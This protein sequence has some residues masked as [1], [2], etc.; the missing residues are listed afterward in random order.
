MESHHQPENSN[1]FLESARREAVKTI[2]SH[3]KGQR[4]DISTFKDIYGD[5]VNIDQDT[6]KK[7]K[8]SFS[9]KDWLEDL[10]KEDE[11]RILFA[12]QRSDALEVV[13]SDYGELYCWFGE[14]CFL[15]RTSEYD[16]FVNNV[17]MVLEYDYYEDGKPQ[18]FALVLDTSMRTTEEKIGKKI[19]RNIDKVKNGQMRLKYFESQIDG[20]K[21]ELTEILPVVVG[22]GGKTADDLMTS[23]SQILKLEDNGINSS[24]H[25]LKLAQ[26]PAQL[27]LLN[28]I[29]IQLEMYQR[30]GLLKDTVLLTIINGVISSQAK[31][32][33]PFIYQKISYTDEI[34]RL[35]SSI[36]G[37]KK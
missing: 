16:D 17:D 27:L 6:V 28:E 11:N 32:V 13:I 29:K 7:I 33:D 1:P 36:A 15:Q 22:V 24:E 34:F 20:F 35:V 26:H 31:I 2:L 12:H 30:L 3:Q 4:V 5:E 14:N 9:N 21:G 10:P 25:K 19:N 37:S 18:R 23:V 8:I